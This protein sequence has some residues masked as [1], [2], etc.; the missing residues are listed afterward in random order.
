MVSSKHSDFIVRLLILGIEESAGR[1]HQIAHYEIVRIHPQNLNIAFF[2]VS[3]RNAIAERK[4]PAMRPQCPV[5]P[6]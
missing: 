2:P 5:H 6:A 1:N 3:D 4:P